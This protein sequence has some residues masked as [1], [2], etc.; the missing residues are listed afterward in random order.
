VLAIGK[1]EMDMT[2][3]EVS[4]NGKVMLRA[5]VGDAGAVTALVGWRRL[6][7][8]GIDSGN[9]ITTYAIGITSEGEVSSWEPLCVRLGDEVSVR[10]VEHGNPD[11]PSK[12]VSAGNPGTSVAP[13][14]LQ[15]M[16]KEHEEA[17]GLSG[18]D[19]I[20]THHGNYVEAPASKPQAE[21][22]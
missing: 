16:V 15:S 9:I 12:R 7:V 3:L 21:S 14:T 11:S 2:V 19:T 18:T 13:M 4:V 20:E 1:R 10:I 8:D 6:I 17:G 5:G 22:G